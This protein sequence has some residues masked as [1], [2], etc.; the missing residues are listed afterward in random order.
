MQVK[1]ETKRI[2]GNLHLNPMLLGNVP[3]G[4]LRET[5]T[6]KSAQRSFDL[7]IASEFFN[8]LFTLVKTFFIRIFECNYYAL[9]SNLVN[10]SI[11]ECGTKD[12][13][14]RSARLFFDFSLNFLLCH[15]QMNIYG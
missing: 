2:P 6:N 15:L 9:L 3:T 4:N 13:I 7:D 10:I 12:E 1:F 11:L 5:W 8:I 14:L